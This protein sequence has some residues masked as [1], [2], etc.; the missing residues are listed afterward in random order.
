M[1][2]QVEP[3]AA[4]KLPATDEYAPLNYHLSEPVGLIIAGPAQVGKTTVRGYIGDAWNQLSPGSSMLTYSASNGF[5]GLASVAFEAAGIDPAH[6]V[7]H[8][9]A[10]D[11]LRDY[12]NRHDPEELSLVIGGLY[13]KPR[14]ERQLRSP[15]VN[16]GVAVV[17]EL[18]DIRREI[19]TAA[20]N[21]VAHMVHRVEGTKPALVVLD[22]RNVPEQYA[23]LQVAKVGL[24]GNVL[25]TCPPEV[26]AER[27]AAQRLGCTPL[28][29]EIDQEL[30][31]LHARNL[32][33]RQGNAASMTLP[34]DLTTTHQLHEL[35][36]QGAEA[37]MRA[38]KDIVGDIH[39]GM[40]VRTDLISPA[41]ERRGLKAML[42]GML[43]QVGQNQT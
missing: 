10:A 1:T 14:S 27:V 34:E 17:S 24:L 25:P 21:Y 29:H 23:T 32:I 20:G 6:A 43:Y 16:S 4:I 5:R 31:R 15:A 41:Q 3:R 11:T 33:D 37:V 26:V 40:V 42:H 39:A 22:A 18:A 38:S 28:P 13:R 9:R 7:E 19:V 8:E 36:G 30:G 2:I 12:V 35:L